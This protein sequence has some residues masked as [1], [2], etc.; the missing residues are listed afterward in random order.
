MSSE[1]PTVSLCLPVRNG[2]ESMRRALD[3]ALGQDFRDLEV[4]VSD[5]G[6]DDDTA[7]ILREYAARDPR[8]RVSTNAE[9]V[10]LIENVNIVLRMARGKYVRLLGSDDW[11]EPDFLTRCLETLEP[12]PDAVG[13]T[14]GFRAHLDSGES[15]YTE[16]P[17][18]V[19]DSP[20]PVRRLARMLWF[21]RAGDS[22]YDPIHGLYRREAL[23]RSGLIRLMTQNDQMLTAEL[24][25]MGPIL[26]RPECLTHRSKSYP[27]TRDALLRR[28]HPTRWREVDH[29]PLGSGSV[30]LG[31][32][33]EA[34][35]TRLQTLRCVP[36]VFSY[37]AH[38]AK[39]HYRRKLGDFRKRNRLTRKDAAKL[40]GGGTRSPS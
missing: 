28:L 33:L 18:E 5:N 17:G 27:V 20:D 3:S 31:I 29:G 32:V 9:N 4:V 8:V 22:L 6:S 15:E 2:Q 13:V 37:S 7:A 26:H 36:L 10:G 24:A 19:P 1:A 11:I 34:D 35:L 12:R 16:D 14:S 25:L 40:L 39:R 30:L 38:L 21:Y 23:E